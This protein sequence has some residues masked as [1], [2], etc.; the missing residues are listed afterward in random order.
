MSLTKVRGCA[1]LAE[2]HE[3]RAGWLYF[4]DQTLVSWGHPRR[5]LLASKT[6]FIAWCPRRP[7][8][9]QKFLHL[10]RISFDSCEAFTMYQILTR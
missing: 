1:A 3:I 4:S 9:G 7:N 5:S 2:P 6:K 10:A 8:W